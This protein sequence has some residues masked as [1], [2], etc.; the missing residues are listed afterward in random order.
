[1]TNLA[2][3]DL[4]KSLFSGCVAVLLLTCGDR[5]FAADPPSSRPTVATITK[6][7]KSVSR[8]AG[9][10]PWEPATKGNRLQ[11]GD[12]V[13]TGEASLTIVKFADNSLIRIREKSEL[14]VTGTLHER[15]FSKAVEMGAGAIG[16]R[17][18][19]Q[20]PNEEFRFTSPTSVASIRG[21]AG[22]FAAADS[23]DT[24]TVL[25]GTIHFVNRFSSSSVEVESG[26]TGISGRDGLIGTSPS[27]P[28]QRREAE[29]ALMTGEQQKTL[30]ME[31]RNGSGKVKKLRIEYR[32]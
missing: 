23:S 32:E 9:A 22:M 10:A 13:K 12:M 30:E 3:G 28:A 8:K 15:S 5:A 19:K 11:T 31:L 27:S 7:V 2:D 6:V 18:P 29:E 17:I 25:E 4:M 24:L 26:E 16:F 1:M 14:T 20:N 21:T